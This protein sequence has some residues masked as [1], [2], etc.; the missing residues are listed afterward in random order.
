MP[1]KP[2]SCLAPSLLCLKQSPSQVL[3]TPTYSCHPSLLA[4]CLHFLLFSLTRSPPATPCLSCLLLDHAR[5]CLSSGW[6]ANPASACCSF[7]LDTLPPHLHLHLP[8]PPWRQEVKCLLL[9]EPS[10]SPSISNTA[11]LQSLVFL[12]S[13]DHR[14]T[15]PVIHLR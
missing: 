12:H 10:P 14:L 9:R 2:K 6:A 3:T 13:T 4:F 5:P 11:S 7:H 15:Y 8:L 1:S